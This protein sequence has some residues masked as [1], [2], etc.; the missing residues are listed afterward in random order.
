MKRNTVNTDIGVKGIPINFLKPKTNPWIFNSTYF[1]SVKIWMIQLGF[2]QPFFWWEQ[3]QPWYI[4]LKIIVNGKNPI[5]GVS[6]VKCNAFIKTRTDTIKRNYLIEL[7]DKMFFH[8]LN[9]VRWDHF[10]P[11]Y[12]FHKSIFYGLHKSISSY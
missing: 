8:A 3:Q 9:L 7:V 10:Q 12:D 4:I 11:I 5:I 2:D 1:Y 6:P